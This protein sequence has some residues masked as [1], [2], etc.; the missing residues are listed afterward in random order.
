MFDVLTHMGGY[1]VDYLNKQAA[2][3][4][5][6]LGFYV[7]GELDENQ[8]Y[9]RDAKRRLYAGM[10][11]IQQE[12]GANNLVSVY[13]DVDRP[14]NLQRPAYQQMKR[15]LRDGL[16]RRVFAFDLQDLAGAQN[17]VHDLYRLYEELQGFDLLTYETGAFRPA[18][19]CRSGR[20][21]FLTQPC[22]CLA[23]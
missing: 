19:F 9:A 15:D 13:L 22:G 12:L 14:D 4:P 10:L 23:I 16:F 8:P 2:G 11:V 5:Q 20:E 7:R 6:A 17:A 3:S 21:I 1:R 18:L